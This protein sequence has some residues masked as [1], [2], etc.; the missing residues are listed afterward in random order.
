MA[1]SMETFKV[2]GQSF[3]Y[4]DF[5]VVPGFHNATSHGG[6]IRDGLNVRVTH[7]GDVILKIEVAQ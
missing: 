5:V 1:F 7:V 4:S 2:Q 6:P 3:S